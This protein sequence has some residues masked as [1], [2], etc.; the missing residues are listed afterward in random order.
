MLRS[1][2]LFT[3]FR[4]NFVKYVIELKRYLP[5]T[6]SM[7]L[8]FYAIFV[9]MLLGVRF[10]GD[11]SVADDNVRYLLVANGFWFLL[12]LGVNSMGWE[13]TNEALRGTLEQ[14][15]MSTV[16]AWLIMLFRMLASFVVNLVIL[17][18]LT[19]L[20]MATAGEWLAID[21]V[22]LTAVLPGTMLGVMGLGFAVAGLTIVYKQV[23]AMLQLLQFVLMGIAFVPLSLSPLMELA[24]AAK[25][26]DMVRQVMAE[27]VPLSSFAA[28][29]WG[30]LWLNGAVYFALGLG[31]FKLLE[32]RAMQRGLLGHY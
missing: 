30:S 18:V 25:G 32:R 1:E 31:V 15:Y 3:S 28:G 20:S 24:P 14:L 12:M 4:A 29:D 13:L 17:A 10:V 7:V 5:N 8:T 6:L 9:F 22:A 16:P 2:M 23:N 27:G 19:V 11:P 21:V 26:I